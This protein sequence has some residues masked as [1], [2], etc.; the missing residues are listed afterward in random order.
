MFLGLPPFLFFLLL[1]MIITAL[2]MSMRGQP[3][4]RNI[5]MFVAASMVVT[6]LLISMYAGIFGSPMTFI[7]LFIIAVFALSKNKQSSPQVTAGYGSQ[8]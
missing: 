8:V 2:T 6:F 7:Y 4:L 5:L 3:P 1:A